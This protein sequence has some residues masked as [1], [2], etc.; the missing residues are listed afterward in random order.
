MENPIDNLVRDCVDDKFPYSKVL[1][2]TKAFEGLYLWFAGHYMGKTGRQVNPEIL[3]GGND[4][5]YIKTNYKLMSNL[6]VF[7]KKYY[8]DA[9]Y[10]K[11]P[12]VL[13]RLH[14]VEEESEPY[15]G[16]IIDF[17]SMGLMS[18]WSSVK[19]PVVSHRMPSSLYDRKDIIIKASIEPSQ[20]MWTPACSKLCAKISDPYFGASQEITNLISA[21]QAVGAASFE[22]EKEYVVVNNKPV[23]AVVTSVFTRSGKRLK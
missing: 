16:Q 10:Y 7:L 13:Y 14:S 22:H 11:A 2:I 5:T 21:I 19:D 20:V 8:V 15:V 18:S 1:S 6:L 3:V 17:K 4:T 23:K 12:N 9:G